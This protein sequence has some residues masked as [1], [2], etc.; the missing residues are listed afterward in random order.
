[1]PA[2]LGGAGLL[3]FAANYLLF[4][5]SH[6][7]R[8]LKVMSIQQAVGARRRGLALS[9]FAEQAFNGLV[10]CAVLAAGCA[11]WSAACFRLPAAAAPVGCLLAVVWLYAALATA[12]VRGALLSKR[13]P[14]A[15]R[16]KTDG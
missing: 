11:V 8:L 13:T 1:M 5:Y 10:V 16:V 14:L 7:K 15:Q 2:P 9:F 12:L 3:I 4:V 6:G